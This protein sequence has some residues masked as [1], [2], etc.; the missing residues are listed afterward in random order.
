MSAQWKSVA[1]SKS[2]AWWAACI[3]IAFI[4]ISQSAA[5]A[6][7]TTSARTSDVAATCRAQGTATRLEVHCPSA[8]MADLL[9]VLGKATG[10]RSEYPREFAN[11]PVSITRRRASLLQVLENALSGFNFAT[12]ADQSSPSVTWVRIVDM[13]RTV[14]GAQPPRPHVDAAKPAPVAG[15]PEAEPA[16]VAPAASLPPSDTEEEMAQA[17]ESFARSVTP[18][19]PL[20]VPTPDMASG[21]LPEA[22]SPVLMKP[23]S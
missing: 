11:A 18:A 21:M 17:R 19:A 23:S 15:V 5:A 12:W 20:A 14:D 22:T 4:A 7:P 13:R 16:A 8:T 9:A 1:Q 2:S 10:L 6:R 3:L